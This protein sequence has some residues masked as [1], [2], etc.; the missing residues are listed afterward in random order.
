MGAAHT[1]PGMFAIT[2]GKVI[3]LVSLVFTW[4]VAH[5]LPNY[6]PLIRTH[7][8]SRL[9]EA[10]EKIPSIKVDWAIPD[11][12]AAA[13]DGSK[14]ALIIEPRPL[15]HLVPLLLHMVTVVPPDWRFVFIGSNESVF[16]VGRAFAVKHQQ[17]V[18]KLDLMVLP[19]PWDISSKEMVYRMLTDLRFYDEFLPGVEWI[20]K[21]ESDSILCGNSPKSLNDWLDWAWAGAPKTPD[22]RFSGN[23]GLSLRKVS[24]IRRVLGFQERYNNSQPE[25]EWFGRRLW[26]LPGEKVTSGM[27]ALAVE[28]V[29]VEEPMGYHIPD[30]G[31]DLPDDVWKDPVQRKKI[32]DYCPE[33][34]LIM[35]MKLERERCEGDD[36]E[37]NIVSSRDLEATSAVAAAAAAS[38]AAEAAAAAAASASTTP[39]AAPEA[40]PEPA[41]AASAAVSAAASASDADSASP[42]APASEN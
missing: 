39:E 21:Y 2:K 16:S 8:T 25:D 18:G 15:P 26:V 9:Q 7:I 34:S 19:D 36:H 1:Q 5:L 24:A 42:P 30:G 35:D 28:G 41:S 23:G 12:P 4:W 22:D 6:E 27:T 14:I 13:F 11:E 29:Y 40:A 32:F 3:V 38:D 31:H 10:R 33:I 17:I 37:G 20:L